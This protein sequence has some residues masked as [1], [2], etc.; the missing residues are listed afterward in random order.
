MDQQA[1]IQKIV[2]DYKNLNHV[3]DT[4]LE[5]LQHKPNEK[6]EEWVKE[7]QPLFADFIERTKEHF[8]IEEEGGFMDVVLSERP[9]LAPVVENL[10]NDH[11]LMLKKMNELLQHCGCAEKANPKDIEHLC[12]ELRDLILHL[13]HH[14]YK[15]NDLVQETLTVEL[16]TND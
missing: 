15:E 1:E 14:E 2:D 5:K 10:R 9:Y 8:M 13:K 4:L 16:G 7:V 3:M 11:I 6:T 12:L